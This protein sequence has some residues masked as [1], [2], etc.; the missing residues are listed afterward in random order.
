MNGEA[1]TAGSKPIL[2][3][4]IGNVQPTSLANITVINNH[5]R[6]NMNDKDGNK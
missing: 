5:I 2:L 6:G 3:A 4:R 1:I